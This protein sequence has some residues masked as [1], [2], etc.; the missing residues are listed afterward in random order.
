MFEAVKLPSWPTD[1]SLAKKTKKLDNT[2][3][4][5][6]LKSQKMLSRLPSWR[7]HFWYIL[8]PI[9]ATQSY[10]LPATIQILQPRDLP[11]LLEHLLAVGLTWNYFPH[12]RFEDVESA[13]QDK[14]G[15]SRIFPGTYSALIW[16]PSI[17]NAL[18]LF[19]DVSSFCILHHKETMLLYPIVKSK[20][21]EYGRLY[22]RFHPFLNP[23]LFIM[24]WLWLIPG[25]T[26]NFGGCHLRP[27][28][29]W[30]TPPACSCVVVSCSSSSSSRSR[31]LWLLP[32]WLPLLESDL[33]EPFDAA[34]S[35]MATTVLGN[36]LHVWVRFLIDVLELQHL[37][38]VRRSRTIQFGWMTKQVNYG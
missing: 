12:N 27:E 14:Q 24:S 23:S 19:L 25:Q 18:M 31:S 35:D 7:V 10:A 22:E 1:C 15:S 33:D 2:V 32:C 4:S 29:F 30:G 21:H 36:T 16:G 13:K 34:Y 8:V 26:A 11:C 6:H 9:K 17:L 37:G 5:F 20:S 3:Q 38:Q 28:A